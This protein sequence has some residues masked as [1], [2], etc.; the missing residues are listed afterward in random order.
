[1]HRLD[2]TVHYYFVPYRILWDGWEEYITGG[3]SQGGDP[4]PAPPAHPYFEFSVANDKWN[5]LADYMGIPD[6]SLNTSTPDNTERVSAFPFAAYKKIWCDY[7]MDQNLQGTPT[8]D[9]FKLSNGNNTSS[10]DVSGENFGELMIR[11]WEHDYFTSALPFAQKGAPVSIP[12]GNFEDV[13]VNV[14]VNPPETDTLAT[15]NT[16]DLPSS[17]GDTA[18]APID[19]AEVTTPL[20]PRQLYARTSLLQNASATINDLRRAEQLQKWLESNARAGS[21]Y[22]ESLLLHFN[23]RSSD[24]RL[25]RAEYIT[26]VKSPII[27]S[28]VL[29]TTG[30]DDLPQGNMSGHA[31]GV[32]GGGYGK[33]FFCEEHGVIIGIMSVMP[34][35]A[36][37]NGVPKWATKTVDRFQYPWP[38]FANIGE[39]EVFNKEVFAFQGS[40]SEEVFGYV[41]RYAEYKFEPNRVAGEFRTSLKNWQWGRIFPLD[42][43]PA[44]NSEFI[45]CVPRLDPFAVVDES[46][47]H[48]YCHILNKI[49]SVRRLPKYGIPTLG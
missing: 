21:R 45:K 15:W 41:P 1:M 25:Q 23:V 5:K 12:I 34:K 42:A 44:L 16:T 10:Y 19:D 24:A 30:T 35:T 20:T 17:S 49:S 48:L 18:I 6:P 29:N 46:A 36:Y 8:P 14:Q 38:E 2:I 43:P 26:G 13:P 11:A 40:A 33:S 4:P 27:I 7:Y 32:S 37:Q 31:I 3:F 22:T 28:E 39:Q 9:S 47:D